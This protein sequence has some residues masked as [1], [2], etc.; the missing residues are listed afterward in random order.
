MRVFA[1]L[2]GQAN[3]L[4]NGNALASKLKALPDMHGTQE[5]ML[6]TRR[7]MENSLAM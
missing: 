4:E 7:Q 1:P 6:H 5:H 3:Q 2:T